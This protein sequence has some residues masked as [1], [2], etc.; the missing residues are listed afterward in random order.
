[1]KNKPTKPRV[2]IEI[3]AICGN[4]DIDCTIKVSRRRWEAIS[5][6]GVYSTSIRY[7]YEGKRY[8]AWWGF[9]DGLFTIGG[10][11]G[12]EL[13]RDAPISQLIVQ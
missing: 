4:G 8:S 3:T 10:E 5:K 13:E 9:A 12:L 7:Y 2:Y 11:D 1:M 6:G